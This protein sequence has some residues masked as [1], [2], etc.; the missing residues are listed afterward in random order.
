MLQTLYSCRESATC[1]DPITEV[2]AQTEQL[3]HHAGLW[4]NPHIRRRYDQWGA[5]LKTFC[6]GHPSH[7]GAAAR[8]GAKAFPS[9]P[10][11]GGCRPIEQSALPR[12]QRRAELGQ[13]LRR[14]RGA[15]A[16]WQ[17]RVAG[18][19][20]NTFSRDNAG[21]RGSGQ[22]HESSKNVEK[23]TCLARSPLAFV[24]LC[25]SI[26]SNTSAAWL[27]KALC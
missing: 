8:D 18:A 11:R 4:L 3:N 21:P 16:R 23:S 17:Q 5:T 14:R 13:K 12:R 6:E 9:E 7:R 15:R 19:A 1:W 22:A 2:S 25:I 20:Q 27:R 10:R 26:M 24:A